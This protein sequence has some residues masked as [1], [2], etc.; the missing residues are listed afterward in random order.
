[1]SETSPSRRFLVE[2]RARLQRQ[3][4]TLKERIGA[5]TGASGRED[6]AALA[7]EAHDRG[8]ESLVNAL[9]GVHYAGVAHDLEE[10][11]DVEAALVRL[12]DGSYGSCVDCG[13]VISEARLVAYPTA[14]RCRLCQEQHERQALRRRAVS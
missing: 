8:E 9:A 4:Q 11:R 12:A 13:A 1:M 6:Q 14:K 5:E 10:A 2:S 3:R 7:S